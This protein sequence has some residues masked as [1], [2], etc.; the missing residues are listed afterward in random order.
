MNVVS[1]ASV[2]Y[3]Q[4]GAELEIPTPANTEVDALVLQTTLAATDLWEKRGRQHKALHAF[5]GHAY[6]LAGKLRNDESEFGRTMRALGIKRPKLDKLYY[7]VV[8]AFQPEEQRTDPDLKSEASRLKR[9]FVQ[10]EALGYTAADFLRRI[11]CKELVAGRRINGVRKLIRLAQLAK[12]P[13]SRKAKPPAIFNN[14]A[15]L[16]EI[17]AGS[18]DLSSLI[19][20]ML[21]KAL[22]PR[23]RLSAMKAAANIAEESGSATDQDSSSRVGKLRQGNFFDFR[24]PS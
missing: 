2:D 23:E 10:A 18:I 9:A 15:V 6:R 16:S 8:Q 20:V 17:D 13:R 7:Q 14:E 21:D 19:A 1:N 12:P 11:E 22:S 4:S 5:M 24:R 3:V